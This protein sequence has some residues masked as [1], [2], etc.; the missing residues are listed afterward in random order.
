[1][2]DY[3]NFLEELQEELAGCMYEDCKSPDISVIIPAYNI[4]DYIIDCLRSV[5]SQSLKNIEIIVV[6]DGSTDRTNSIIKMF[7][8]YDRRIHLIEQKNQGVGIAKNNAL[9]IAR[10]ECIAFVDSDDII[11]HN[12]LETVYEIYKNT[13]TDIVIFGAFGI[14]NGKITKCYYDIKRIHERFTGKILPSNLIWNDLFSLPAVAMCKIYNRQFLKENNIFFQEVRRGEDQ[15][16]FIK[17]LLLAARLYIINEN[18]YGYRRK[19]K[20]SLTSSRSKKD[21]SIILNFYAIEDFL[22]TSNAPYNIKLLILNKYFGKCVSWLGKC[23]REYKKEYFKE[24]AKL[25]IY[26]QDNYPVLM[27]NKIN[28]SPRS[29]YIMLKFKLLCLLLRRKLNGSK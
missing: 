23:E 9:K 24:L 27:T 13:K 16:F 25:L 28:I 1:M 17:S 18:I 22:K 29:R 10:G 14:Y 12:A 8:H 26:L 15:L 11:Q 3:C 4:E 5:V 21:N 19:R 20:N 6:D 2:G 7:M